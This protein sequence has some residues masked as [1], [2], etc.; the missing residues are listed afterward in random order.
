[1]DLN[2]NESY[3]LDLPELSHT[4]ISSMNNGRQVNNKQQSNRLYDYIFLCF[5]LGNDFL[6]HFPA[7]NIRTNGIEIM[8]IVIKNYLEIQIRI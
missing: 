5:F 1:M 8:L 2:P 7:I 4:I 3:I 6:P